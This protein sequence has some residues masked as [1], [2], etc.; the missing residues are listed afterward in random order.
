MRPIWSGTISFGLVNIPVGVYT[1]TKTE[2]VGFH[3][4]HE[5]DMGRISYLKVCKLEE[6][7]VANDEIVKGYEYEK[8]EYVVMTDEDFESVEVE[9]TRNIE[10]EDFVD[11][12]DIDPMFFDQPYY[13][14]PG[15]G[16]NAEQTYVLLRETLKRK[17][18]VGIGKLAI[19]QREYL[20]AIKPK[21][22]ALMLDT[23]HF[24]EE[25]RS[26][27]DLNLPSERAKVEPKHIKIA[28][29]LVDS[30]SGPFTPEKYHDL[31][32][33]ALEQLIEK[34]LKGVKSKPATRRTATNVVDIMTKLNESLKKT[35]GKRTT[36][37]AATKTRATAK[38][39]T[40]K[41]RA[42]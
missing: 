4:L 15:K 8:G 37:K 2:R 26:V 9:S 40:T 12:D 35:K 18:K 3:L 27:D 23:M 22:A 34:K 5:K 17:G 29:Q 14:A 28:E 13:L 1:A 42:A 33:E 20:A 6:E 38:K 41:K 7:P 25:I 31:Y 10:I 36:A 16:K 24:A 21:G 30:L 19:R 32:Q 11:A 39:R